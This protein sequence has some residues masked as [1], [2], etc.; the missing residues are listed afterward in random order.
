MSSPISRRNLE[1]RAYA[2]NHQANQVLQDGF[3][4]LFT[5]T[6]GLLLS[7]SDGPFPRP[8]RLP[9]SHPTRPTTIPDSPDLEQ[10]E[11]GHCPSKFGAVGSP[12]KSPKGGDFSSPALNHKR[13]LQAQWHNFSLRRPHAHKNGSSSSLSA[14]WLNMVEC[15]FSPAYIGN[16]QVNLEIIVK[17]MVSRTTV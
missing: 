5:K 13:K 4:E 14:S 3:F 9:A 15:G 17:I 16:E 10:I 8:D 11:K 2:F 6:G 1:R 12:A 7:S